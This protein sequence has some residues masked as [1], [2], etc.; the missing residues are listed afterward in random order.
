VLVRPRSTAPK[1]AEKQPR[2]IR[3][4]CLTT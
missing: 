4:S 3:S 1:G 2:S